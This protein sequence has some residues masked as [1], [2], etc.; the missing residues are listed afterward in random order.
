MTDARVC[1]DMERLDDDDAVVGCV[2]WRTDGTMENIRLAHRKVHEYL[3]GRLQIVGAVSEIDA[4]A[5]ALQ[6][7]SE[8]NK[9]LPDSCFEPDTCGDVVMVR[10]RGPNAIPV[11]LFI[12]DV[13]RALRS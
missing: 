10:T 3:G 13:R 12:S 5:V 9:H 2:V 8:P 7:A 1:A 11:D 4:V 6:D